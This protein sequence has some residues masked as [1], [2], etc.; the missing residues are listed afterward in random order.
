MFTFSGMNKMK[1]ILGLLLCLSSFILHRIYYLAFILFGIPVVVRYSRMNE[2]QRNSRNR[3]TAW[4]IVEELCAD[5]HRNELSGCFCNVLCSL[6]KESIDSYYMENKVIINLQID[7][8]TVLLKSSAMF[9]K[10]FMPFPTTLAFNE[11]YVNYFGE[12]VKQFVS[13]GSLILDNRKFL[14]QLCSPCSVNL[15]NLTEPEIRTLYTLTK[16][17]EFVIFQLFHTIGIFPRILGICGHMYAVEKLPLLSS[18]TQLTQNLLVLAVETLNQLKQVDSTFHWCDVKFENLA[19]SDYLN[20]TK[21]LILDADLLF[22]NN[23][24][25]QLFQHLPCQT[26]YDCIFFDCIAKCN[27]ITQRCTDRVN[28]NFNVCV[29]AKDYI[30][31]VLFFNVEWQLYLLMNTIQSWSCGRLHT[32]IFMAVYHSVFTL[33]NVDKIKAVSKQL[34]LE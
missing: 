9:S 32:Y 24:M 3:T 8:K 18:A 26:D 29:Q 13:N 27:P 14:Q 22:T 11:N 25:S 4:L 16:Q 17:H 34:S 20:P 2:Y 31:N 23:G 6:N 7:G 21:L 15:D 5:F 28:T 33:K 30:A 12:I 19:F 1:A 10:Q